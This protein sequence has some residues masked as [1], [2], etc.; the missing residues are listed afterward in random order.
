MILHYI[1]LV[2]RFI[3]RHH[4]VDFGI[5]LVSSLMTLAFALVGLYYAVYA[6]EKLTGELVSLIGIFAAGGGWTF[7][8]YNRK[9]KNEL[10]NQ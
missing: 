7:T 6:P 9:S 8:Q 10:D 2:K 5:V 1:N 4:V 3:S